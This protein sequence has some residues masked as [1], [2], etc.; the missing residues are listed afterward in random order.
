MSE[1]T[2]NT[3]NPNP[4]SLSARSTAIEPQSLEKAADAL[5][6]DLFSEIDVLLEGSGQL[7]TKPAKA[8]YVTLQSVVVPTITL[9]TSEPENKEIQLASPDRAKKRR[10]HL[11]LK[12]KKGQKSKTAEK[13]APSWQHGQHVDKILLFV[14]CLSVLGVGAWLLTRGR[15]NFNP[16][17]TEPTLPA[18]QTESNA[19]SIPSEDRPFI[20]YMLRSLTAIANQPE[21]PSLQQTAALPTPPSPANGESASSANTSPQV[22]ERVY[23]P[24]YPPSPVSSPTNNLSEAV[25]PS[26]T[27]EEP[28][29]NNVSESPTPATSPADTSETVLP[30]PPPER[31]GA[32]RPD[33][34]P[35][36]EEEE[37]NIPEGN[38]PVE[39]FEAPPLP[40]QYNIK[41][42]GVLEAGDNSGALFRIND[43]TERIAIGE[44]IGESG[45][46]LI[47]VEGQTAVIER[48]G[49]T[50]SIYVGQTF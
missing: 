37:S 39:S 2:A 8:E 45:W 27:A 35:N 6:D 38:I 20:E 47:R 40:E 25:V 31:L 48:N 5:M 23:I 49:E 24:V 18:P 21:N 12:K 10:S 3:Q 30:D 16:P 26:P 46:T 34:L 15:I 17:V 32:Y 36:F 13:I 4:P 7:P 29:P 11:S 14:A 19:P 42:A 1:E 33:E 50:R 43:S 44:T 9:P 28:Q 22:I 41:L